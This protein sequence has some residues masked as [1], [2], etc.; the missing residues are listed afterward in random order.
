MASLLRVC[1]A[2]ITVAGTE[3]EV[4]D[5]YGD[6]DYY[7][8][9][10][11][12][13]GQVPA[14]E[15]GNLSLF[16]ASTLTAKTASNDCYE[17]C[18]NLIIPYKS[19]NYSIFKELQFAYP[20]GSCANYVRELVKPGNSVSVES[21]SAGVDIAAEDVVALLLRHSRGVQAMDNKVMHSGE[22]DTRADKGKKGQRRRKRCL[23]PRDL[24]FWMVKLITSLRCLLKSVDY[25]RIG[26]GPVRDA[27]LEARKFE[28]LEVNPDNEGGL[29]MVES[30]KELGEGENR[31]IDDVVVETVEELDVVEN[32]LIDDVV[33]D[34]LQESV[35]IENGLIED[36]EH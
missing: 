32:G 31:L 26:T 19:R 18:S 15:H 3:D 5:E 12:A 2:K 36:V 17:C 20:Q 14:F 33:V 4:V 16:G 1:L 11:E 7:Y 24:H 30:V 6:E 10:H 25:S 27:D 13:F 23:A 35:E 34:I 8:K 29:N 22:G 21:S 9:L 28:R